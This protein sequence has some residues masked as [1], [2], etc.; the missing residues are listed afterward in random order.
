MLNDILAGTIA[1]EIGLRR[2][3]RGVE[4]V[5]RG[6]VVDGHSRHIR[7]VDEITRCVVEV[8]LT[9]AH[10]LACIRRAS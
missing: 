5:A 3:N 10:T 2:N 8:T 4:R 9:S 1:V 6:R 7:V